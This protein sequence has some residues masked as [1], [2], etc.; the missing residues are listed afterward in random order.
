MSSPKF[1]PEFLKNPDPESFKFVG[2]LS[3]DDKVWESL[4]ETKDGRPLHFSIVNCLRYFDNHSRPCP[5]YGVGWSTLDRVVSGMFFKTFDEAV[6]EA[7]IG[8]KEQPIVSDDSDD[9]KSYAIS[10]FEKLKLE[11]AKCG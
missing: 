7:T 5:R 11:Y 3:Y 1:I 8:F 4:Y 2:A 9:Y 10:K 6:E